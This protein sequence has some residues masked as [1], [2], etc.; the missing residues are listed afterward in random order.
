MQKQPSA[1]FLQDRYSEK[2]YNIHKKT[3]MLQPLFNKVACL[4]A[5]NF[6]KKRLQHRCFPVNTAKFDYAYL[7]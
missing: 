6:I 2:F 4:E 7:L 1:D 3:F 5:Y